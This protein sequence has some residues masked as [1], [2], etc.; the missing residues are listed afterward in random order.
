VN[1]AV[2][3]RGGLSHLSAEA[4]REAAKVELNFIHYPGT[5]QALSDVVAGR[6][7]MVIDSLSALLGPAASGDI[8][9]VAI[10]S[11]ERLQKMPDTPTAAETVAGFV[12]TAWLALVARSGTARE[13]TDRIEQDIAAVLADGTTIARLEE[14]GTYPRKMSREA[15]VS[16]IDNERKKWSPVVGKFSSDQR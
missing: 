14:T 13:I 15:L 7:P 4:W 9:I 2:S 12:A 1:C 10:A 8:R 3:T 11:P 16:F 5:S 6:V